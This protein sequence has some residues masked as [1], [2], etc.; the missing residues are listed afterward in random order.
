MSKMYVR[1]E[2]CLALAVIPKEEGMASAINRRNGKCGLCGGKLEYIG[3]VEGNTWVQKETLCKCDARCTHAKGPNCDCQCGGE[4]HGA[5]LAGD[6]E[7]IKEAGTIKVTPKHDTEKHLAMAGEYRS[8]IESCKAR[9]ARLPGHADHIRGN[10]IPCGQ[11]WPIIQAYEALNRAA[12]GKIHKS[13]MNK[14]A[15]IAEEKAV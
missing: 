12:A 11:Y 5:G 6:Y 10:Q 13:R 3:K 9:I 15:K 1:C 14:L 4:N 7:Y 8:A 2:V